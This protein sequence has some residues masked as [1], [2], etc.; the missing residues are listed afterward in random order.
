M[1]M[2]ARQ[3]RNTLLVKAIEENDPAGEV[4]PLADR[5]EATRRALRGIA[6]AELGRGTAHAL[7]RPAQTM[8]ARRAADLAARLTE[9]FPVVRMLSG[10]T[11][12]LFGPARAVLLLA[13]GLGGVLSILDG[14]SRIEILAFPL[15][16][17]ILWNVFV[18]VA[19][20]IGLFRR[21]G[22]DPVGGSL[23]ADAYRRW[24]QWRTEGRLRDAAAFNA[25]LARALQSFALEWTSAARGLLLRRARTMLH[26]AAAATALG[27]VAGLYVKGIVLRYEAGWDSTFL[28]PGQVQGLLAFLYGP[29]AALTGIALPATAAEAEAL[30]WSTGGR[31]DAAPWIHLIAITAAIYVIVPRTLLALASGFGSWLAGRRLPMPAAVITYGRNVLG[32]I[33]APAGEGI[34]RVTPYACSPGSESARGLHRLLTAALGGGIR[35]DLAD[36]IRFGEEDFFLRRLGERMA[37]AA[38]HEVLVMNLAAT[39]ERENHGMILE[40]MR[41]ARE[42]IPGATPLTV[43]VDETAYAVRMQGDRSFEAR[44]AERRGTWNDFVAA[45]GVAVCCI[46]LGGEARAESVSAEH[47]ACL[48]AALLAH[49]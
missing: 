27:L 37:G 24:V 29:A 25:P 17:L 34:V 46:D 11:G 33:G 28:G 8:L 42:R 1:T 13:V 35:L 39:P 12:A 5:G 9:R 31:V 47:A 40:A 26:A 6:P 19:Q 22:T 44:L 41:D 18:Y 36:E 48:R 3:L 45:Y 16:G 20:L 4:L 7:S 43:V 23:L 38:D 10:S 15:L 2:R 32:G 14:S 49:A 21:R 30:R